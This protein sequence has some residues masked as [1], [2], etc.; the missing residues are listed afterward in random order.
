MNLSDFS[1]DPVFG[2]LYQNGRP[3]RA[4][5]LRF[6]ERSVRAT[7]ICFLLH[8]G[9]LPDFVRFRNRD[10]GDT[11]AANL[12]D[13]KAFSLP[14]HLGPR[15]QYE[16]VYSV[17]GG[18][19]GTTLRRGIRWCTAV[20]ETPEQARDLRQVLKERIESANTQKGTAQ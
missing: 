10:P 4:Q 7:R 13:P 12:R 1:Y 6:G 19:Q 9:Y 3:V 2:G 20:T 14:P 16:G 11:R 5:Y 8:F 15:S 17:D 18:H